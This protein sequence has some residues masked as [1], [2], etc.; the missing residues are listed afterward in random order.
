MTTET[1]FSTRLNSFALG[2]GN[3][4]PTGNEDVLDLIKIAGTV[5][6]LTSLEMNYPE[7][8]HK[9][10]V[11]EIKSAMADAGLTMEAIQLRWP[12]P[13]FSR[14]G[15]TN[16]DAS[17]RAAA[18][19]LVKE[20]VDVARQFGAGH[21]I[22]WPAHDGYEYPLQLNYVDAWKVLIESI[23]E[24]AEYAGDL[25][26]SLEYKP[27]E[28]RGRTLLD[29]TGSVMYLIEQCG[30]ANL[31]AT[32]DFGHLLMA[33]ESPAQSAGMVL[34]Q[35][36]LHG[37]Q[38]ND[39]FGAADD[40]L[41]VGTLHLTEMLEF[42]YYLRKYGYEGTYYFD[43]DPIRENPVKEC[44]MNIRRMKQFIRIAD[45]LVVDLKNKAN[46][47]ALAVSEIIWNRLVAS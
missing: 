25:K 21:V 38:L 47:D 4:L 13:D 5:D 14:G 16:T 27:A 33:Q 26:V 37:V 46:D 24:V 40:G 17:V 11:D 31:G 41:I 10:S 1:K 29:S 20:A 19:Q 35:K 3:K 34:R 6:G 18:V 44:E 36:K 12:S 39:S 7:H 32:L 28:P 9:V 2:K 30:M 15:F 8:F 45:E 23:K 43:T 22:M 42:V